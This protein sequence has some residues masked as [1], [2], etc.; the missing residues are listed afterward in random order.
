MSEIIGTDKV[1]ATVKNGNPNIFWNIASSD[2]SRGHRLRYSLET[3]QHD[4]VTWEEGDSD[5]ACGN[6]PGL[7]TNSKDSGPINEQNQFNYRRNL[8]TNVMAISD[9]LILQT[10][11]GDQSVIYFQSDPS[12]TMKTTELLEAPKT[13]KEEMWDNN[14]LSAAKWSTDHINIG[15]YN[16]NYY[17]PNEKYRGSGNHTRVS[18]IFDSQSYG[19]SRPSR[20]SSEL[21][22]INTGLNVID[23]IPNGEYITGQ[24]SIFYELRLT[25]GSGSAAYSKSRNSEYGMNGQK[26]KTTYSDNHTKVNDI[27]IHNPVSAEDA[28]V[29]PLPV[30]RDQ[31]T[32]STKN[33]GGN[34]Q[35][36]LEEVEWVLDCNYTG[37]HEH[38]SSC[39]TSKS[40]NNPNYVEPQEATIHTFNYS[41]GQQTFI[42]PC[43]GLYKLET[44]GAGGGTSYSDNRGYGG[45]GGYSYGEK[46]LSKGDILYIYV[47]G[48]GSDGYPRSGYAY[49]GYNGGGKWLSI[50]SFR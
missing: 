41:G 29:I 6:M 37:G 19:L 22:L 10:S 18:T 20:P 33:I 7:C 39:Y 42:A 26:F 32:A 48:K 9:F 50:W 4:A 11:S 30:I 2:T 43:D 34:R 40:I 46:Y 44:W 27:V 45:K 16:G 1:T 36:D 24:S 28:I 13:S 15:S 31:R 25:R 17:R 8:T 35:E 47:G 12:S 49:G 3:G 5:N 38:T 14:S 21:R 23:T